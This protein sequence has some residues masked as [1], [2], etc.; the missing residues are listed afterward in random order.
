MPGYDAAWL[1]PSPWLFDTA[2]VT[3]FCVPAAVLSDV[4]RSFS[5]PILTD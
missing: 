5:H 4:S 3:I 2:G 1:R